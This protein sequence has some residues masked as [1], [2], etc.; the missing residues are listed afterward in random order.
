MALYITT[1]PSSFCT[2]SLSPLVLGFLVLRNKENLTVSLLYGPKIQLDEPVGFSGVTYRSRNVS[3]SCTIKDHFSMGDNLLKA[4]NLE[5]SVTTID[6]PFLC[7]CLCF[8]YA[9]QLTSAASRDLCL[10][11]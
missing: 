3:N 10:Y 8:F 2:R 9:V 6:P 5:L 11:E 7:S 4:E 1:S